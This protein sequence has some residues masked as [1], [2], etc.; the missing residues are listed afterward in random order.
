MALTSLSINVNNI[1]FADLS[2]NP[3]PVSVFL[4]ANQIFAAALSN[5]AA[6]K[7]LGLSTTLLT[8]FYLVPLLDNLALD[9]N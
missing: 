3:A 6:L 9:R 8:S 7:S 4:Q 5:N 2:Q 1:I